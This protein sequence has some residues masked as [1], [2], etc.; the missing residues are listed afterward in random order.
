MRRG[1]STGKP[2]KA[3]SARIVAAKEGPCMACLV[4]S[5]KG[6]MSF[7]DVVFGCDYNHAKSGNIRR[8]H[9]QGYALCVYHHRK[10]PIGWYT[11][12]GTELKYGP[13]LMDGSA[14]FHQEYGSDDELIELQTQNTSS[15]WCGY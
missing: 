8:G 1:R 11:L 13:S 15:N 2:T 3:E 9:M 12:K 7:D 6:L 10:H 14:L 4:R 5:D